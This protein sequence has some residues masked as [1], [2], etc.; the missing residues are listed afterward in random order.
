MVVILRKTS[1]IEY[2]GVIS[3]D[4]I[5]NNGV[6][7]SIPLISSSKCTETVSTHFKDSSTRS[8]HVHLV[9]CNTESVLTVECAGIARKP[10][11]SISRWK[12][13]KKKDSQKIGRQHNPKFLFYQQEKDFLLKR[14]YPFYTHIKL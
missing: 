7:R 10:F 1:V 4:P 11:S 8:W 13:K 2:F 14:D 5:L 6:K 9:V 3:G 12:I